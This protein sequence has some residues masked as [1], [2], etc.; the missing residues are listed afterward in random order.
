MFNVIFAGAGSWE[1]DFILNDLLPENC[2]VTD[3]DIKPQ[4]LVLTS[5][6]NRLQDLMNMC[7]K[8]KPTIIFHLSDEN[9]TDPHFQNIYVHAK[10]Y[11]RQYHHHR[12]LNPPNIAFMPLGY[13]SGMFEGSSLNL[14]YV[15]ASKRNLAWSFIGDIK[16]SD[17]GTMIEKF[18]RSKL[19]E[20][21]C[22]INGISPK[23]MAD[24]YLDTVFVPSGRGNVSLDCFRIYEACA[25][26]AIPV[27]VGNFDEIRNTFAME[28]NPPW[29]IA[30]NWDTAIV[31]CA[32]YLKNPEAL[33]KKQEEIV[34]WWRSRVKTLQ[35]K[36]LQSLIPS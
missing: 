23:Q 6:F 25:C 2:T 30:T 35:S 19:G 20:K 13:H 15:S 16:K 18:R 26:G 29:I 11:I 34:W 14:T 7:E 17:R 32:K 24:T 31:T 8:M 27:V 21:Y 36:I 28:E 3:N 5:C 33:N 10:L 22:L 1:R 12:Y 4:I 9:G